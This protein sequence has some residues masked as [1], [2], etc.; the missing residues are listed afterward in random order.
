MK[1]I[2]SNAKIIHQAP[3]LEGMY[4]HIELCGRI[5][6]KSEDKVSESSYGK[7]VGNLI[8]SG[9]TSVLEHGTVY[10]EREVNYSSSDTNEYFDKYEKNPYSEV[11]YSDGIGY[12][13]TNFRVLVENKWTSDLFYLCN[14]TEFHKQRITFK[15]ITSIGIVRELLRHRKFSFTNESTRYCNYSKDKF[16]NEIVF[17][18]PYWIN[19]DRQFHHFE[20][21]KNAYELF[22]LSCEEAEENYMLLLDEGFKPEEAREFL[23][24]C[25]KSELVMTGFEEDWLHF[26]NLRLYNKTG[27][28]HPDMMFLASQIEKE[29][30]AAWSNQNIVIIV[31]RKQ[32]IPMILAVFVIDVI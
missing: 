21:S 31:A 25:T 10:M 19:D 1:I 23:P 27:K 4:K 24:L 14:P 17:I 2:N 16:N 3:E 20:F 11:N 26:L 5:S 29:Y 18:A 30:N 13:T 15:F 9:H 22:C 6:Y 32:K 8:K 28:S 7:F 12:V